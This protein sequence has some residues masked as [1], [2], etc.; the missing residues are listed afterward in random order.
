MKL[1]KVKHHLEN[2]TELKFKL[3]NGSFVPD[4]FHVTEV[5]E[6]TKDFIDCDGKVR[7]EK[8]VNFQLWEAGDY[9][10]RLAPQKLLSIIT[11]AENI[12]HLGD[13]EVEVEYQSDTI[14]KYSL[15]FDG[16]T[17]ELTSK[18]TNCLASDTCGIPVEKQKVKLSK[19][20]ANN[21]CSP[22]GGCC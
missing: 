4:H 8:T 14:G 17:F 15:D 9:D 21:N 11:L 7:K 22:E 13:W 12:L 19:L 2:S 5:G 20:Q 18:T 3:P 16:K 6:I 10:H 1:S